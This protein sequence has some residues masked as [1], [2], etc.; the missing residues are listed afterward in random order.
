MNFFFFVIVFFVGNVVVV[1]VGIGKKRVV[2]L[3]IGWGGMSFLKNLDF[4]FYDVFIV[5]LWNYFV[6]MLLFLSVIL[7]SVEV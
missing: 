5:V 4:M 1:K 3:G 6:F 2:V 7:G